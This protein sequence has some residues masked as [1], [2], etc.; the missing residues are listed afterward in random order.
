MGATAKSFRIALGALI[1]K[2]KLGISDRETVEQIQEN[3]YLQYF[4][5]GNSYQN[6][7]PFDASTMVY[8]R[9]RISPALL[10]K[11]NRRIVQQSL[12]FNQEEPST[13]KLE[14]APKPKENRGRLLM[15][16]TVSPADIKYP[17]DVDLLNQARKTTESIIDLLYKSLKDDLDKKPRTYR[18]KARKDYLNFAKK[19][20]PSGKQRK[21]A[22]K[23]Q[24]QYIK[25]NLGHIDK[26]I[27]KRE[28]L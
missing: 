8:F 12:G 22:V 15:D 4:I 25:R 19:R 14:E 21:E 10:Q 11:I 27:E 26:L 24:L 9:S 17:T 1:I 28:S 20:N 3:P 6:G 2:E 5:G 18:K 16:A 23:K 13:K 7:A